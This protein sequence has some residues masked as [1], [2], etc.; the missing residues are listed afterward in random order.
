MSLP[1][2]KT[3]LKNE[4]LFGIANNIVNT[5]YGQDESLIPIVLKNLFHDGILYALSQ[6]GLLDR[7]V[8]QGGT[9]LQRLYGNPRLS[10]LSGMWSK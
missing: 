4:Y 10:E 5:H 3:N 1:V 8:F 2:G 9:A 6:S 7:L